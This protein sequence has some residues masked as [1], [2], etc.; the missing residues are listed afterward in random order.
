[1]EVTYGHRVNSLEDEYIGHAER[2]GVATVRTGSPGSGI[3]SLLVGFFPILKHYPMWLPGSGFK[4][5]T[6]EIRKLVEL[7][8]NTPYN[9]VKE[10][11][12]AGTAAPSLTGTLLEEH[13]ARGGMTA[14]AEDEIRRLSGTIYAAGT[15]TTVTG[16]RTFILAMVR[17]PEVFKKA[18]QE[19]DKVV[20]SDRL[21]EFE[22][23]EALSYLDC[24]LKEVYRWGAP[25]PLAIPH[26]SMVDDD[27]QGYLIPGDTMIIPN[28]W[29]S[30]FSV[31]KPA[32]RVLLTYVNYRGMTR[33][34]TAYP[35]PEVF[36]PE[37]FMGLT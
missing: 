26:R 34:E 24:I 14:Q 5:K 28:I 23:R 32:Y 12:T 13:Y 35:D 3:L 21:P 2:A 30:S 20:G 36:R 19:I 4:V 37:R 1:M 8:M 10:R 22:D 9:M 33:N 15:D 6:N 27:Y 31:F 17:N 16:L 25:V 29:Y 7:M 11:L 18:Q